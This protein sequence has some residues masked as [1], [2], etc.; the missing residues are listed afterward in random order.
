MVKHFV[1]I[2]LAVSA[3]PEK[4]LLDNL[5][6]CFCFFLRTLVQRNLVRTTQHARPVLQTEITSVCVVPDL[7][8]TIAKTVG[9]TLSRHFIMGELK[10]G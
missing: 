6:V 5:F 2:T 1:G 9:E 3:T 10:Q 4:S 8:A 7:L